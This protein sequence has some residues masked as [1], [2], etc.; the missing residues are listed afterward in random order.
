MTILIEDEGLREKQGVFLN[1]D[2]AAGLLSERLCA[3]GLGG[4][5][6]VVLAI[7]S[8]GVPLGARIAREL[9]AELDLV[10]VRKVQIPYYMEAGFGSVGPDGEVFLNKF[11]FSH[12]NLS[13]EDAQEQIDK[14]KE[15][16]KETRKF[17]C[18]GRAE[19]NLKDKTV[20]VADD[21]LASGFTMLSALEYIRRQS[22]KRLIIA[23]PTAAFTTIEL[24]L[25][26]VDELY[27]LNVRGEEFF[28]VADAYRD[29]KKITKEEALV[30]FRE[31]VEHSE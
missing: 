26:D 20:I 17:F 23:V 8:G 21:G 10:I 11:L 15:I 1:R 28:S 7:P 12:L 31:F 13:E 4:D 29:W 19:V 27:C 3:N 16:I 14:A 5:D 24:L 2:E 9:K 30:V 6:C 18:Q 25:P 22:P